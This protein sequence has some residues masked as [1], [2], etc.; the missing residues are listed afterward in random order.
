[1]VLN[2]FA[3]TTVGIFGLVLCL[4]P[5]SR[6]TEFAV[7][8][9]PFDHN[10]CDVAV[11]STGTT[12]GDLAPTEME[13]T[14]PVDD[15]PADEILTVDF[16]PV[17]PAGSPLPG[18]DAFVFGI[19]LSD[20]TTGALLTQFADPIS[21][22]F[23]DQTLPTGLSYNQLSLAY[24]NDTSTP[25]QWVVQDNAL[26]E[27]STGYWCGKTDHFSIFALAQTSDVPDPTCVAM[28]VI[29][30]AGL[31]IRHRPRKP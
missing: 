21:I 19:T 23:S 29:A 15:L 16:N 14:I 1:M 2:K 31:G 13:I 7:L 30:I 11:P 26:A 18:D 28:T 9:Q 24:F 5:Q 3:P 4:A 22:G 27:D 12:G 8:R 17:L 6:A 25:A 20:P 10:P